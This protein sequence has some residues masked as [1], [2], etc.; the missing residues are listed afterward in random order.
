M[1]RILI[2]KMSSLGDLFHALP[3]V[4]ALKCGLGAQ[5]DWVVNDLYVELVRAFTDVDQ[6]IAFPRRRLAAGVRAFRRAL[7]EREYDLVVDLQ[8]LLKSALVAKWARGARRIGPSFQREGA[9]LF[10]DEVAGQRNK[11]RH[12]VDECLDVVRHLGLPLLPA[13][14][15]VRFPTVAVAGSRPRVALLPCSR[16]ARK[17]WPPA[18]FV[19]VARALQ[20]AIGASLHLL[21]GPAD[22][23]VCAEIAAAAGAGVT[24]WC[25]RTSLLEMGGLLREMDLLVT[26]DS[27][28]MHVAAAVGTPV[29]AVFGP[30]HPVRT[31]PFGDAHIVVQRGPDL[32][33]LPAQP[34]IEAALEQLNRSRK[35]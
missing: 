22:R 35:S 17:N 12:A 4:H 13:T 10:Y 21:G 29:V 34:V 7:R 19:E 3:T 31:G 28:P 30:T 25:G 24:D 16:Q 14:F 2:I 32:G 18:R 15:P 20:K 8:G 33:N 23:A 9:R 6:V 1:P 11:N 5:V 27:G 26:V